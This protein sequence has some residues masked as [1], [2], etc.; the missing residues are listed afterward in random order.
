MTT[1]ETEINNQTRMLEDLLETMTTSG[2]LMMKSDTTDR[3][4]HLCLLQEDSMHLQGAIETIIETTTIIGRTAIEILI[5]IEE[6]HT[7]TTQCTIKDP[8]NQERKTMSEKMTDQITHQVI[9]EEVHQNIDLNQLMDT[10]T[11]KTTH[12]LLVILPIITSTTT[13]QTI[14]KVTSTIKEATTTAIVTTEVTVM[15]AAVV[16]NPVRGTLHLIMKDSTETGTGEDSIQINNTI[17]EIITNPGFKGTFK[18]SR[19]LLS[20]RE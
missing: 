19:L 18:G 1:T 5:Q 16:F 6:H 2:L 4:Q 10:T 11:V 8:E 13:F 12:N 3:D 14:I 17:H 9:T 15:E 20:K 7:R